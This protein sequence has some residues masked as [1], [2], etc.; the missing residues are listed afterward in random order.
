MGAAA[1]AHAGR[2]R[3]VE[4]DRRRFDGGNGQS[5][6]QVTSHAS[7]RVIGDAVDYRAWFSGG[8]DGVGAVLFGEASG[9]V[10][11][12]VRF[13]ARQCGTMCEYRGHLPAGGFGGSGGFEHGVTVVFANAGGA[14]A[15]GLAQAATTKCGP[16]SAT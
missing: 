2:A 14:L 8:G 9:H 4:P 16:T 3:D 15:T 13:R 1:S 10:G 7:W 5:P 11:R 6:D 12:S